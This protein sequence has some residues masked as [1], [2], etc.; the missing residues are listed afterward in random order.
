MAT[1]PTSSAP[2]AV[3]SS[4]ASLRMGASAPG[5][6]TVI[7]AR[8]T[9][10]DARSREICS[11]RAAKA[12]WLS[13]AA[14]AALSCFSAAW[15]SRA[16][17]SR[18]LRSR[19]WLAFFSPF[20][21]SDAVFLALSTCACWSRCASS[22]ACAASANFFT[23][24]RVSIRCCASLA[25]CSTWLLRSRSL[26]LLSLGSA[27]SARAASCA[28]A[29]AASDSLCRSRAVSTAS[30]A[31]VTF[32]VSSATLASVAPT[33]V[34][35]SLIRRTSCS[36]SRTSSAA[37]ERSVACWASCCKLAAR[38]IAFAHCSCLPAFLRF[39]SR[40]CRSAPSESSTIFCKLSFSFLASFSR[41][42]A[43]LKTLPFAVFFA[44]LSVIRLRPAAPAS[45]SAIQRTADP[46]RPPAT[47]RRSA[48]YHCRSD[49]PA[50][51]GEGRRS[52]R[53]AATT[54]LSRGNLSASP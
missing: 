31:A 37:A 3:A 47:L 43:S 30:L 44:P 11:T 12:P 15:T 24:N 39:R 33:S 20:S 40:N 46:A 2:R 25:A 50:S 42:A 18:L 17:S 16:R 48:L 28:D 6:G 5:D 22:A 52:R 7:A 8:C 51:S 21:A 41:S 23:P 32:R 54:A 1:K 34:P 45:F 27:S 36:A 49:R 4:V 14:C 35:R 9:T 10:R 38:A 29:S 53:L 26:V 13:T 19:S